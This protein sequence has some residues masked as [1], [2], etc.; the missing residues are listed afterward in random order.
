MISDEGAAGPEGEG[1]EPCVYEY[2]CGV[3]V[4]VCG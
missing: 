4:C 1:N 2:V 3:C